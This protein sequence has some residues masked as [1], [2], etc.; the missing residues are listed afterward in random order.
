MGIDISIKGILIIVGVVFEVVIIGVVIIL[1][2]VLGVVGVGVVVILFI[3]N[4]II[5]IFVNKNRNFE[6]LTIKY[7]NEVK[8]IFSKVLEDNIIIYDEYNLVI[9]L[10]KEYEVSKY[11]LKTKNKKEVEKIFNDYKESVKLISIENN[12]LIKKDI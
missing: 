12:V 11:K 8:L 7:L 3:S 10:K 9:N 1:L 4:K 6:I 2:L 5:D